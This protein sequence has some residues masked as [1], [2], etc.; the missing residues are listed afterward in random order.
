VD[1]CEDEVLFNTVLDAC[2]Y[3]VDK[4][5]LSRALAALSGSK[6]RPSV[7]TYG[8]LIKASSLLKDTARCWV[9]WEEMTKLR[10]MEPNDITL[11]CMMD[12]LIE[13]RNIEDAVAVFQEWKGKVST[14]TII[15]STLI[16]GFASTGDADR[17]MAAYHDMR[18]AGFQMNSVCYTALI[19]AHA[20]NGNMEQATAL[21]QRM[22]EDGCQPNTIT[23]S[24]LVKGYCMCGNLDLALRT[25]HKMLEVGLSADTV[26]FNTML[27]GCIRHG[28]FE[29]A[30]QLLQDMAK[31]GAEPTNFTLSIVVKMWGKRKQLD[32]AFQAVRDAVQKPGA[33]H[34]DALVGACLVGA[35]LHNGA[36][37]RAL[38]ALEEIKV[39]PRIDGPCANTY[40]AIVCGFARRGHCEQAARL[41]EEAC[42]LRPG[43]GT[44]APM[45]KPDHM[46]QLFKVLNQQAKPLAQLLWNRLR[47]AGAPVHQ[48]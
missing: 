44:P 5:R 30:D 46:K 14:N 27:D 42:G 6:A 31:Y 26:I 45:L 22:E 41:A 12:A 2:I 28:C 25:F 43:A 13:G 32:K 21:F 39:T 35:C 15:Y 29:L 47:A 9:F 37:E 48:A 24:N 34:V 33:R 40:G 7:R 10:R 3:R 17:A 1:V 20:R 18:M 8:L 36:L 38:E 11:S 23:Y 19:D 16:K 4:A